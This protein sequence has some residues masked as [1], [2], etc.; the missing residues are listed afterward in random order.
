LGNGPKRFGRLAPCFARS[1][2]SA[3][4]S[5]SSSRASTKCRC[6][7]PALA[8]RHH[9]VARYSHWRRTVPSIT[10]SAGVPRRWY[11]MHVVEVS[12]HPCHSLRPTLITV[13]RAPAQATWNGRPQSLSVRADD[14]RPPAACNAPGVGHSSGG[15]PRQTR[16]ARAISPMSP[17]T[18]E[19]VG[20][21]IWA[22]WSI[23]LHDA[24]TIVVDCIA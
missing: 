14:G 8:R 10:P 1:P 18:R 11:E 9:R 21:S 12:R 15:S 24:H 23:A 17:K 2:G 7:A 3:L 5:S 19:S 16:G 13:T 20:W 6:Q 22:C 4:I